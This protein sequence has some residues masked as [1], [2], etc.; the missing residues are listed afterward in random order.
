V[1]GLNARAG[2]RPRRSSVNLTS[3]A[4]TASKKAREARSPP[5]PHTSSEYASISQSLGQPPSAKRPTVLSL[6]WRR[7]LSL[8]DGEGATVICCRLPPQRSRHLLVIAGSDASGDPHA[9][10][11]AAAARRLVAALYGHLNRLPAT[12]A[13]SRR[14]SSELRRGPH[15]SPNAKTQWHPLT[16]LDDSFP[17]TSARLQGLTSATSSVAISPTPS[18]DPGA[19]S[20]H[21]S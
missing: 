18:R 13:S 6:D 5:T 4:E 20:R 2:Q 14:G 19:A 15:F 8:G 21:S 16:Y 11:H 3:K 7:R 17:P 10:P 12:P 1:K 9:L